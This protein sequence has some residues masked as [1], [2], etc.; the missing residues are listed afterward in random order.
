MSKPKKSSTA[1]KPDKDSRPESILYKEGYKAAPKRQADP[2]LEK[3]FQQIKDEIEP[4]LE[5]FKKYTSQK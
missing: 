4:S 2:L 3:Y 5:K 1:K